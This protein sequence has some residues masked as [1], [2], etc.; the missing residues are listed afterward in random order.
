MNIK[1]IAQFVLLVIAA[2][3]IIIV[4]TRLGGSRESKVMDHVADSMN[5]SMDDSMT[6]HMSDTMN[7]KKDNK[8]PAATDQKVIGGQTDDHGCLGGA[9]YAWDAEQESCLRSWEREISFVASGKEFTTRDGKMTLV[10]TQQN[11]EFQVSARGCN[12][13]NG[14]VQF[15]S[16][17]TTF[18]GGPF[19]STMM[20][21]SDNTLME[22]DADIAR[23]FE[24]GAKVVLLGK[25][26]FALVSSENRMEFVSR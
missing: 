19:M 13:T 4:V 8:K 9:G 2:L 23:M 16:K 26:E 14:T 20:A 21:C 10:I 22:L 3:V 17:T 11:N 7:S 6:N 12:S 15:D 5:G 25:G 18:T 1:K 24:S